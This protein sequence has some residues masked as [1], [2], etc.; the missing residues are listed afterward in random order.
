MPVKMEEDYFGSV[1][2]PLV[3]DD[4]WKKFNWDFPEFTGKEQNQIVISVVLK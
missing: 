2:E 1:S 3:S 4:V